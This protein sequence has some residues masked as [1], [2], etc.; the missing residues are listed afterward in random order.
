MAQIIYVC[1]RCSKMV[2][3]SRGPLVSIPFNRLPT[4]VL[5]ADSHKCSKK[6]AA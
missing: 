2:V 6:E 3:L 1:D 5:E 4:L